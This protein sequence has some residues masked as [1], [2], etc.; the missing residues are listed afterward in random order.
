MD[1]GTA[2]TD[3]RR[4]GAAA[5]GGRGAERAGGVALEAAA[6]AGSAAGPSGCCSARHSVSFHSHPATC[7]GGSARPLPAL[8][9]LGSERR[10]RRAPLT[11]CGPGQADEAAAAAATRAAEVEATRTRLEA[12]A[13]DVEARAVAL[14]AEECRIAQSKVGLDEVRPPPA[15]WLLLAAAGSRRAATLSPPKLC[16]ALAHLRCFTLP[17]T[18]HVGRVCVDASSLSGRR[19]SDR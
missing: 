9:V 2:S 3:G 6:G 12:Q 16:P 11:P 14:A 4:R 5:G 13:Q 17:A 7:P 18:E 10:R 15:P 19:R 8:C 1:A